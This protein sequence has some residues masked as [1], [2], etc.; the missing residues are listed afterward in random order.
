ML[1]NLVIYLY[2]IH[3]SGDI[4]NVSIAAKDDK[5]GTGLCGAWV[6]GKQGRS[7][8]STTGYSPRVWGIC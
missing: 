8:N 1:T 4:Q 6:D 3:T 2:L 5:N 7:Y